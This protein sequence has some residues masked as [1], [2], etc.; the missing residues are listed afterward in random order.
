MN[1]CPHEQSSRSRQD[2]LISD[3]PSL[4]SDD[5]SQ[6]C[7]YCGKVIRHRSNLRKHIADMHSGVYYQFRCIV[8][9]KVFRT[10]NSMLTHTYRQ[11]PGIKVKGRLNIGFVVC[12]FCKKTFSCISSLRT[13]IRDI[14]D[15]T[16]PY[17]CPHC[18]KPS[19]SQSGLRMHIQRHH[20]S[21]RIHIRDIHTTSGP[22]WCPICN[23]PAKNKNALRVHI[24]R[25]HRRCDNQSL[26][27]CLLVLQAGHHH[28]HLSVS[29]YSQ[30]AHTVRSVAKCSHV[31]PMYVYTYVMCTG[32]TGPMSATYATSSLRVASSYMGLLHC[33]YCGKTYTSIGNL[34]VHIKDAHLYFGPFPCAMCDKVSRTQSGLRMHIQRHHRNKV[35]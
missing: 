17:W 19:K 32:R 6:Y 31:C 29:N 25:N 18:N 21:L 35:N 24:H 20:R 30:W 1:K 33:P 13:H 9:A 16:G 28:Q 8:C 15:N 23:K 12:S 7:P 27:Q 14:H 4:A 3:G 5:S 26:Q 22:V 2:Y 10:K 11:H 34:R